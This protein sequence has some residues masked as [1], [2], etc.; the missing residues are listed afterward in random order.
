MLLQFA[1]SSK[2]SSWRRVYLII[3]RSFVDR[4]A[5]ASSDSIKSANATQNYQQ[6]DA[7]IQILKIKQ[8]FVHSPRHD[9]QTYVSL[10]LMLIMDEPS[11]GLSPKLIEEYLDVIKDINRHGTT[12]VLIEQNAETALSIAHRGYLLVKGRVAASEVAR[13]LLDNEMI[14]HLYS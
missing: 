13:D 7:N 6:D 12:I 14:R 3:R 4:S 2:Y 1:A 11:L 8:Y 5:E 9:Q 10:C